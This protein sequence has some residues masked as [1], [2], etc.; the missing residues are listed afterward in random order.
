MNFSR[1]IWPSICL[2]LQATRRP[3]TSD[4]VSDATEQVKRA[5]GAILI[6][7]RKILLEIFGLA[8]DMKVSA[9]SLQTTLRKMSAQ[10]Q[11]K[12]H[13]ARAAAVRARLTDKIDRG[14]FD[15]SVTHRPRDLGGDEIAR[16]ARVDRQGD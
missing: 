4:I 13:P 7:Y 2:L 5:E 14:C 3:L 8:E 10:L 16:N 12:I 6:D 15:D 11:A 1:L 9:E